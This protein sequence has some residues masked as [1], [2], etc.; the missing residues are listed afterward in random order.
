[1]DI[2]EE[3]PYN[4]FVNMSPMY[5]KNIDEA[6]GA[7]YFLAAIDST[8]PMENYFECKLP[9]IRAIDACKD[10][11][12]IKEVYLKYFGDKHKKVVLNSL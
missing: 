7:L 5:W 6:K 10:F 12:D 8:F 9:F 3:V 4:A 2:R 1:M 11:E